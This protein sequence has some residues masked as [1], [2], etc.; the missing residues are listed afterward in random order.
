MK[1]DSLLYRLIVVVVVFALFAPQ[2]ISSA[3]LAQRTT[4][5]PRSTPLDPLSDPDKPELKKPKHRETEAEA[6][7]VFE[8]EDWFYSRRTAGNPNFSVPEAAVARANAADN[9]QNLKTQMNG[10]TPSV[11]GGAWAAA[12]PNPIVQYDRSYSILHAVSGRIGALAVRSTAPYTIYLGAAQGGLWISSTLTS[13]WTPKTDQLASLAVGAVALAP[14]NEDIVYV[15]TGEGAL[16]G[17]SYFGNGVLKSTDGGNTF[18]HVSGTYFQGVSISKL[19]V[20][21]T[22]PNHLYAAT[23]RG[24]GGARR[25]SPPFPTFF[26]VWESNDGGVNWTLR[27]KTGAQGTTFGGATDIVMDPLQ[28]NVLYASALGVG[29]SKTVDGGVNWFSAM[30]GLPVTPY[31]GAVPSRLNLGISHPSAAVSATLYTGFD[32]VDSGGAYHPATVWKTTN[33]ANSWAQTN[34]AIVQD[35]CATQ[36][37]YDNVIEPDP[38]DANIIYV[39]GQWRYGPDD[40]GFADT[41]GGIF[42][43]MDG[44]ATWRDIGYGLHPDFHAVAIRK[45]SPNIVIVGNDGGV[46]SS[47]NRGGRT[48]P[49]DPITATSWQDLNG[50]VNPANGA[51]NARTNLQITQF[52]SM[53]QNPSIAARL[54]G[55]TQDNGTLRKS[56][57]SQSW[58]DYASGD[59][60]QVLVDPYDPLFVYGTYF[61]ISPYRFT[62]GMLSGPLGGQSNTSIRN[63]INTSDRAEFY[64]P[65]AMDPD[66]TNRLF[67]GTYRVYRT[68]NRG[69]LWRAISPDLTTGCSGAAPNGARGCLISAL[70]TTF[71]GDF[72][73]VGT[74]DG[75]VWVGSNVYS[76]SPTW[77]RVSTTTLPIRPVTS[78]AVDRSNYRVAYI[79]YGGF[80]AATP[81]TPGHIFKTTNGGLSFTDISSNLPDSPVNSV[82]VDA[83]D[84]NTIY[85]GTDVGPLMTTNGGF[86]W[87]PLGTGF[88]IVTIWQLDLNPFTRQIAVGTHGRGAWTLSDAATT[89]P[90]LTVRKSAS[91]TPLGPSQLLTYTITVK[92]FG[93]APASGVII[94]DPVPAN[95]TFVAASNGGT[96]VGSSVVWNSLP[97]IPMPTVIT[98]STGAIQPGL[99][100]VTMVVS[101]SADLITG[102][103][104]I[105]DGI[106]V[107]SAQGVGA[108]GSPLVV[109]IAPHLAVVLTP[110]SQTDGARPGQTIS[111]TLNVLN[112]SYNTDAYDLSASGNSWPVAFFDATNTTPITRTANL[113]PGENTNIVVR[114]TVAPGAT[115]GMTDTAI[116]RAASAVDPSVSGT[117]SITTIAVG[118]LVLLVDGDNNAPNVQGYYTATLNALGQPYNIWDIRAKGSPPTGY[119]KAHRVIVWFTGESYPTPLV[120]YEKK[121]AVFLDNGGRL[122]V[123]G[124][125]ILESG[126][127]T[128]FINNYARI[129]F[130]S[131][132]QNDI[133][134]TGVTAVPTNTVTSGLGTLTVNNAAV[135]LDDFND[136][137][138]PLS[139]AVPAFRDVPSNQIDAVTLE[140]ASPATGTQY[141]LMF[142]AF[143]FEAITDANARVNLMGRVYN[144]FGLSNNYMPLI[145]NNPAA[146]LQRR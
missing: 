102:D 135:G 133:F 59:G 25:V 45:D 124:M 19:A 57:V 106:K 110:P 111:Y 32:Y 116:I 44:G 127:A 3:A 132:T 33:D 108:N 18:S 76:N 118:Y 53:A 123:S 12:G 103:K 14:S 46:W 143:P 70:G 21:P 36:C 101:T 39:A 54:Y 41:S 4:D 10:V 138:T 31:Y 83:S 88:P 69:D 74:D 8:R 28:P 81:S 73:W 92:N 86:T 98:P 139:P 94:T 119:L 113:A 11:F 117:A 125:D 115:N 145:M 43:S 129:A 84:P 112:I 100:T 64:V 137:V 47:A 130:N 49:S 89:V 99:I 65:F 7:L 96:L 24:R 16:S 38:T 40:A 42:R 50:D 85:V 63:G 95:T 87:V 29:I 66:Q 20:D 140:N 75:P 142:L 13:V 77:T 30:N 80:N 107:S 128:S 62:N 131:A 122:F 134:M 6:D 48:N 141:K 90:A 136:W 79:A 17:D 71:G 97:A 60:G 1:H 61:G 126:G 67:L 72:L 56:S 114:V 27:L 9:F 82:A 2:F 58:F 5:A 68:D 105:D 78:I 22:N 37:F 109:T 121:L 34:T 51:V 93:N 104:I 35:Y 146:A 52:S 55:G 15:G 120:P 91:T 26:G 23:L 144:F